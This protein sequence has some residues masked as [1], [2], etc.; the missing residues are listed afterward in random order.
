MGIM[1]ALSE[2]QRRD[3]SARL[4]A[5]VAEPTS[6]VLSV[7]VSSV[8]DLRSEIL[9]VELDGAPLPFREVRAPFASRL[10][11][12]DRVDAGRL[13]V[14]YQASVG[15]L[16]RPVD[17]TEADRIELTRP[18]RYCESD[19]L[20]AVAAAEL[21][22]L[23]GVSLVEA[24][25]RWVGSNL[26]Y[27]SG[28]SRPTDGAVVTYLTREGVC[29]D[30]AHLVSALLRARDVPARVVSVYA[31]GLDPMDFHA[32]AEAWVDGQ[33]LAVDATGLAPRTAMVR[34]CTGRDAADTA[35]LTT[36]GGSVELDD[37]EIFAI[38]QPDLPA[39]PGGPVVLT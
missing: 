34:I 36:Q 15:E 7:A 11:V 31:P 12:V 39:D 19:K 9:S 22:S 3:V 38:A 26:T 23:T 10:H 13:V 24:V 30:F 16:L 25:G 35:F 27:V 32:I 37:I 14:R 17:D 1:G 21:G 29:R 2:L 4:H 33:W 6:M 8:Y 20:V 18:S 5:A 28:S